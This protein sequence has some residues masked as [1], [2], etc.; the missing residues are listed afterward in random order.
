MQRLFV[1]VVRGRFQLEGAVLDVEVPGQALAQ[2]VE[3]P[4]A[5]SVRQGIVG[6]HD[7]GGQDRQPAGNGPHMQVVDTEYAGCVA[8][9]APDLGQVD[10]FRGGLEEHVH[11]VP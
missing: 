3:H 7:M 11:S 6:H 1:S 9:V 5:A 10:V 4:G 8:D 2:A